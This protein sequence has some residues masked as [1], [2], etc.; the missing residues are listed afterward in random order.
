MAL[1]YMKSPQAPQQQ[2]LED[3]RWTPPPLASP[4]APS[5][6]SVTQCLTLFTDTL[7]FNFIVPS[8]EKVFFGQ[9]YHKYDSHLIFDLHN[10][11]A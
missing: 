4:H 9:N 6:S 7:Q 3:A 1:H 2:Y 10:I 8:F 11:L 5:S